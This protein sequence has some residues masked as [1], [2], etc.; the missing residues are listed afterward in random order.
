M[1]I[2]HIHFF[3]E[4]AAQTRDWLIQKM[5][6]QSG[7]YQINE[8]TYTELVGNSSVLLRVSAARNESSPVAQY[9]AAHPAGVANIAFLVDDLESLSARIARLDVQIIA[10]YD[11][12]ILLQRSDK[13]L[14]TVMSNSFGFGGTNGCLVMAK[15]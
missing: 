4:D 2:D 11:L 8:H 15:V 9:L 6:F 5:G 7:G 1:K 3:V 12:P 10:E 13:P 14:E